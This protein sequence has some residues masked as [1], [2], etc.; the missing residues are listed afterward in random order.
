M[1]EPPVRVTVRRRWDDPAFATIAL[2]HLRE[3]VIRNQP[4]GICGPVPRPFLYARVWCDHLVD[5]AAIHACQFSTAPH[6]LEVCVLER[7][8][9]AQVFSSLRLQAR[10]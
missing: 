9:P 7:D 10:R 5:G 3:P 4:G 2:D 6:E 8:N 1:I